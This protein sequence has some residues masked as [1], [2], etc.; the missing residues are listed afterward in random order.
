MIPY[1]DLLT[2]LV[3][4]RRRQ[5][6]AVSARF[7]DVAPPAPDAYE[8]D[9][10]TNF[11]APAYHPPISP[12][13]R[14]TSTFSAVNIEPAPPAADGPD[15]ASDVDP[16]GITLMGDDELAPPPALAAP[17]VPTYSAY[18]HTLA[19]GAVTAAPP[20]A[21]DLE[22]DDPDAT[23]AGTVAQAQLD[24]LKPRK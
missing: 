11:A 18:E 6:L 24:D 10:P 3:A 17:Q 2:A 7:A 16:D 12:A 14:R 21:L 22:I 20:N 19:F 9:A 5:G 4:W 23:V 8:A 13:T 15:G 1:Q